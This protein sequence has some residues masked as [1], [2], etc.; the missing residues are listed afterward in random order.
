MLRKPSKSPVAAGAGSY[1]AACFEALLVHADAPQA[2][3]IRP[4]FLPS[5]GAL[6]ATEA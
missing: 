3:K 4:R 5:C 2:G 1:T 6:T